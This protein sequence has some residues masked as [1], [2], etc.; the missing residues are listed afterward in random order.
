MCQHGA[1]TPKPNT[2]DGS[3]GNPA[4]ALTRNAV[5]VRLQ[6]YYNPDGAG[7]VPPASCTADR[8]GDPSVVDGYLAFKGA[9]TGHG[10]AANS[11]LH[12][13]PS[14]DCVVGTKQGQCADKNACARLCQTLASQG[15]VGF[16]WRNTLKSGAKM[17]FM[18]KL[19]PKVPKDSCQSELVADVDYDSFAKV[20][21]DGCTIAKGF[22]PPAK[23]SP[24][25]RQKSAPVA[26]SW[27]RG[28]AAGTAPTTWIPFVAGRKEALIALTPTLSPAEATRSK[29]QRSLQDGWG[30]WANSVLDFVLLPEG[31]VLSMALCRISTK[32]CIEY[33][34]PSDTTHMRVAEHAYDK[35]YV[36][37]FLTHENAN[38][39]AVFSSGKP[40]SS[41]AHKLS[42]AVHS[43]NGCG[44]DCGDFALALGGRYAWGRAGNISNPSSSSIRFDSWGLRDITL[45]TT[46]ENDPKLGAA[47]GLS[48]AF[49][50][51][52]LVFKLGSGG[53]GASND[54]ALPS[55]PTMPAVQASLAK[56]LAAEHATYAKF[57][58][59]AAIKH[60]AQSAVMWCLLYVPAELGPFAPVSR[61]WAFLT[62]PRAKGLGKEWIYVIFDWDNSEC[63]CRCRCCLLLLLLT[64]S[65]S[66]L[67]VFASYIFM[68]DNKDFAYSNFIQVVRSRTAQGFIPNFSSAGEKSLDRTEPMIGAKV[69]L[70]LYTKYQDK[71]LVE[72]L[73][74]DLI[75]WHNWF[76]DYRRLP[77]LNLLCLG[78]DA[79]PGSNYWSPNTL[80]SARLE[81]GLDN[82]PMWDDF[83]DG[84]T[85]HFNSTSHQMQLY[86]LSQSSFYVSEAKSL[87]TLAAAIG[88]S[89]KTAH[90]E[91][92]AATMKGLISKHLWDDVGKVFTNKWNENNKFN[93]R[94]S[95][96]SFYPLLAGAATDAQADA[97][98]TGWL[99]NKS[100]FC[101]SE[102]YE[103][104]NDGRCYWGLPSISADDKS[105]PPLG[106][107]R[108][109]VWGPMAQLTYWSLQEYD[110][111]PSVRSAR[112]A[113]T[114]QLGAMM[115]NQWN[116]HAHICENFNPHKNGTKVAGKVW[117]D[118]CTGTKFYHWGALAGLLSLQEAGYY[119][120]TATTGAPSEDLY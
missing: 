76:H 93:R 119:N 114:K 70:D 50:S 59:Y 49:P 42:L 99:T 109:Y 23:A 34:N 2:F 111:V 51:S 66:C 72:L 105:F 16:V 73:L 89:A 3:A 32:K 22:C 62:P 85:M 55:P 8:R 64:A 36:R 15:C 78:S 82:S 54:P 68:L 5:S 65:S 52:R 61:S 84:K 30:S 29:L 118:D 39:S 20:G 46:A 117:P 110:H 44:G 83:S 41:S 80:Q 27:A 12:A 21:A 116:L 98:V 106:Y 115:L 107:W 71:W 35:S 100:R 53:G 95:P 75:D 13:T 74:D 86:E 92:R 91:E 14:A 77:P 96:T 1:Y 47:C 26:V 58:K 102:T 56:K 97:M 103:T 63:C 7:G 17:C 112:K 87:I 79:I 45:S 11:M 25:Q 94:I 101:I 108:G 60:A 31:A 9:D 57:G 18:R 38:V 67:A 120:A 28:N 24:Q 37:M 43:V 90:L 4:R 6:V 40:G 10:R 88:Q 81:S 48:A 33:T 104:T 69:L 113:M 19:D